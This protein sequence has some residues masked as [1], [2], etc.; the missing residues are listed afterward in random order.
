MLQRAGGETPHIRGCLNRRRHGGTRRN[1]ERLPAHPTPA[2]K[3]NIYP[4]KA[5][6]THQKPLRVLP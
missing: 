5:R 2:S 6:T 1:A 3:D 4:L